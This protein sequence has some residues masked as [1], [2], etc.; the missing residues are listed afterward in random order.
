M[1]KALLLDQS[2]RVEEARVNF[3]GVVSVAR[4]HGITRAEMLAEGNLADLCMSHDLPEAEDH[5]RAALALARRWGLRGD[6]AFAAHNLM[7][8]L[9]M[10][11][12]LDESFRLGS[13]LLS[14]G[15][16]AFPDAE[17][18]HY[19]LALLEA[20][21]G[22]VAAARQ[23]LL[24]LSS[25][26][27]SDDPQIRAMYLAADAAVAL[28]GGQARHALAA[29]CGAIDEVLSASLPVA[30]EAARVAFPI[31]F[32]AALELG[33]LDEADR[34]AGRLAGRS[35]GEVPPFLRAQL[36]RA[37]ALVAME[38]GNDE[39]AEDG[40]AEAE[41]ILRRLGY[42]YWT[43]RVELDRA[44]WLAREQRI[45]ESAKLAGKAA[46]VFGAIGAAPMLA[47]ARELLPAEPSVLAGVRQ[48]PT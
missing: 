11:G 41:T 31:A 17:H 20:L 21:R 45:D 34:V 7:Y 25:W 36:A 15:D 3:D 14:A 47:R 42:P 43:A 19:G 24:H 8:I 4:R 46:A 18:V 29:A 27:T 38:K 10:A 30:H 16:D 9:T 40:L 48:D 32:E 33:D 22:D 44:E 39:E 35:R 6:E 5:A 26:K 28:A 23:R 13:E 2:G 1:A 37:R 12:G